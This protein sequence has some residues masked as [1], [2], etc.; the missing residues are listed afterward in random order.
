[1]PFYA[2]N[3]TGM[4]VNAP[5]VKSNS[6]PDKNKIILSALEFFMIDTCVKKLNKL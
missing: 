5:P 4:K 1:M 6:K 3:S 2:L